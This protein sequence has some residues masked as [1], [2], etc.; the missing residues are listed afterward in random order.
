MLIFMARH[1]AEWGVSPSSSFPASNMRA[2]L[3]QVGLAAAVANAAPES[4][5]ENSSS[6]SGSTYWYANVRHNGAN[7]PFTSNWTVFR[8]VLNYGAIGDGKTDDTAAIRNAITL[9]NDEAARGSGHWGSTGQPAVVFFPPG[10]YL[11]NDTIRNYIG[12]VLMGDPTNRP[13]IKASATFKASTLLHGPDHIFLGLVGFY[14]EIK[15]LVFD[16][17]ALPA[18]STVTLVDWGVSQACQLSNSVFMMPKGATGHTAI[19]ARGMSSPLL[20]NDLKISGG[21]VGYTGASTQYHLKNIHFRGVRTAIRP[22]N[23]VHL[24]IQACRF[25]D[26]ATGVD[27]SGGTLGQLTIIDSTATNTPVLVNTDANQR[28]ALGSIVLEN[29]VVDSTVPAVSRIYA[30]SSQQLNTTAD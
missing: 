16:T 25:E 9:G 4:V 14:H 17:T 18:T 5:H 19:A 11:V 2:F 30:A 3:L 7:A 24:M 21:G 27:M 23:M 1:V 22:T 13:T 8:N 29:I 20:L 6:A 26:V 12:T 15:N 10:T 28:A